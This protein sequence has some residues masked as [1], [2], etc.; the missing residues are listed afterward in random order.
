MRRFAVTLFAV[1][2]GMYIV[3]MSAERVSEWAAQEARHTH[4]SADHHL[5]SLGKAEKSETPGNKRIIERPFVVE[6]PLEWVGMTTDS[7]R[8]APLPRFQ[9]QAAWNRPTVSSRAPPFQI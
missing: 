8:H 1:L 4:S 9:Y 7:R 2:Y 6:S 5:P 3:S